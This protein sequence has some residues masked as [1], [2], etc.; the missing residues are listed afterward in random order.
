MSANS[1]TGNSKYICYVT[2]PQHVTTELMKLN[3]IQFNSKCT[4]VEE[5][6]NKPTAFSQ[7]N[8]PRPIPSVFSNHLT[9]ETY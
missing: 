7:G 8:I 4:I 3:E 5:A 1:N 9:D 6:N 2:A